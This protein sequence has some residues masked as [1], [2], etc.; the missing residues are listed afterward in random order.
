MA[1][2]TFPTFFDSACYL[3][4]PLFLILL[5][6][7]FSSSS[8]AEISYDDHCS[9]IVPQSIATSL[10]FGS[11]FSIS[12]GFFSG[13][14][15]LFRSDSDL[16]GSSSFQFHSTYLYKTR[17]PG[18][19]QVAGTLSFHDSIQTPLTFHACGFWSES[20]GKL[21][22][23]GDGGFH[24]PE[25]QHLG[26]TIYLS[27]VLKL[28]FPKTSTI[29]SSLVSGSLQ[30]LDPAGSPN[31]FDPIWLS[32]YAQNGYDYTMI[33]QANSS[34]SPR[35]FEEESLGFD[36]VWTCYALYSHIHG[37]TYRLGGSLGFSS[38]YMAFFNIICQRDGLLHL[39]I[40]L[41]NVS[42]RYEN[43]ASRISL[44]GEGYWDRS[45]NQLC[46]LACRIL[47]GRN[48]KANYSVGD[49]TIGLSLWVP[50]TMTLQSRSNIVG[51]IWSNKNTNDVGYFSTISFQS[52]GSHMNTIAGPIK[53]KYTAVESVRS[54]C[55]VSG[56]ATRGMRRYPNGRSRGDMGFSISLKDDGGGRGWGQARVLSIGDTYY[57]DGDTAMAPAESSASA[58]DLVEV[59]DG[60][61]SMIR[62][63]SY[64]IN[65]KFISVPSDEALEIAAEGIYDAASGTL[66]MQGCRF[67][68]SIDCEILIKIQL[69]PLDPKAGEDIRGTISS[70]RNKRDS[71]YFHPIEVSSDSMYESEA[72]DS[73]WRMDVE[74]VMALVSLTLSCIC[75]RSQILH[76]KKHPDDALP[77]MSIS[78]LV[79]LVLGYMIPSV[80]NFE[81]L[82]VNPK[83]QNVLLRSG[84]WIEVNETIVRVMSTVAFFLSFRLLQVA[85][86]L[87]SPEKSKAQRTA[88]MVCLPL[89]VAGVL[90][91]WLLQLQGWEELISYAGLV[92]DGFLLPQIILNICRNSRGN[93]LTAFFYLGITTTRA[94]P[95]LYDLY[96]ARRYVP[97]FSSSYIYA[98]G[99]GNYYSSIWDLIAPCQGFAFAVIV[100]VQQRYG[101]GCV[102]PV[103][104]LLSWLSKGSPVISQ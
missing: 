63:V 37:R 65:Y 25:P 2:I 17:S 51:R 34:C 19:Y 59:D 75:I 3:Q 104:S 18:T 41:S 80:L 69:R 98:S 56:G 48:S 101:G 54:S 40:G 67:L 32:A 38:R 6:A 73:M 87:G 103:R 4:I 81:A 74:I 36:P 86:S 79:L 78:M 72:V 22:M 76:A 15:D 45:R 57:G 31:H 35:R 96:R 66:C 77:S 49:C 5:P 33:P 82:F 88:L 55:R 91:V 64:V 83:R 44:V 97:H 95:H 30:S 89:Y 16:N 50:V 23:V 28:D 13:G 94:M 92:L 90:L 20:S 58:A 85:W 84:G 12:N 8:A 7:L 60:H 24:R 61:D 46:L 29:T 42:S 99:D 52:L 47:K 14:G 21:C 9:S 100:Y 62:N 27:A 1:L 11:A 102:L 71:L 10:R 70:T 53:Y 43:I 93:T 39:S 68:D 26:E